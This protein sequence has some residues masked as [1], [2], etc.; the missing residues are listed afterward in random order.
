HRRHDDIRVA[1]HWAAQAPDASRGYAGSRRGKSC[2]GVS[3][4]HQ[5]AVKPERRQ[6]VE[7]KSTT[8]DTRA[9]WEPNK[10]WAHSWCLTL[11]TIIHPRN[12]PQNPVGIAK[13]EFLAPIDGRLGFREIALQFLESSVDGAVLN[14]DAKVVHPRRSAVRSIA[15]LGASA[16]TP[17]HI[18]KEHAQP[19]RFVLSSRANRGSS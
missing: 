15:W 10:S 8:C 2:P 14:T 17:P 9:R 4:F 3:T 5:V 12:L 11:P 13:V 6:N 1:S 18:R 7:S 16:A 19:T